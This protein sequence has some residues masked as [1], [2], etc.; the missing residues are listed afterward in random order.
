[1]ELTRARVNLEPSSFEGRS[2]VTNVLN[3]YRCII[4]DKSDEDQDASLRV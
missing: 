1:M 4:S 2:G 3:E